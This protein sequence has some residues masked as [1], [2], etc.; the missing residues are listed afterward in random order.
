MASFTLR[1]PSESLA[2]SSSGMAAI[3]VA[4]VNVS[5]LSGNIKNDLACTH[6]KIV[7]IVADITRLLGLASED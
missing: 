2:K 5:E 7:Q 3:G 1:P 4:I 6:T